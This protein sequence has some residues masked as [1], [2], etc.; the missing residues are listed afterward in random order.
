ML[1]SWVLILFVATRLKCISSEGVVPSDPGPA[2]SSSPQPHHLSRGHLEEPQEFSQQDWAEKCSVWLQQ[3][4]RRLQWR[5]RLRQHFSGLRSLLHRPFKQLRWEFLHHSLSG[6]VQYCRGTT[7]LYCQWK[8]MQVHSTT[9]VLS[10]DEVT[11]LS[12]QQLN[13]E[14]GQGSQEVILHMFCSSTH[15]TPDWEF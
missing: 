9:W 11:I 2:W 12:F 5:N 7:V 1:Q 15:Q 4:L 10:F 6:T 8:P 3:Q 13:L 14:R